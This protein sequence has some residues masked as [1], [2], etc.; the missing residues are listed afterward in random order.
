V[1]LR[2]G[3]LGSAIFAMANSALVLNLGRSLIRTGTAAALMARLNALNQSVPQEKLGL[4]NGL[5]IMYGDLGA[6]A[7]TLPIEWMNGDFG[8][9][10]PLE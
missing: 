8:W 5:Y 3:A 1:L 9:S 10:A 7:S 2:I 6:I 4:A